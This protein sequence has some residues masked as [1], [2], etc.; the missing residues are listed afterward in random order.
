[1][2]RHPIDTAKHQVD[3]HRL[4]RAVAYSRQ[5]GEAGLHPSVKS[6]TRRYLAMPGDTTRLQQFLRIV[7]GRL[8]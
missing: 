4:A 2:S 8:A 3:P 6:L 1:M 7:R 5:S